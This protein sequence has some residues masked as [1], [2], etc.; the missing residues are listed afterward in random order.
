MMPAPSKA[1]MATVKLFSHNAVRDLD[2]LF[3]AL[4]TRS[5]MTV[6]RRLKEVGYLSS[7]TDAGRY[8][9]LVGIPEFDEDG[10]WF[11]HGVGFSRAGTLK[12]TVAALV[13]AADTGLMH[14]ELEARL[15]VRVHNTL[16]GLVRAQRI[17]RERVGGQFVYVSAETGRLAAQLACRR[18]MVD[19]APRAAPPLP[20][21]LVIAVLVEVLHSCMGLAPSAVIAR[22]LATRGEAVTAEQVQR[23]YTE[24]G[25]VAGK[26]T[27]EPP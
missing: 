25:L 24:H 5:R 13:E 2:A 19:G 14:R 9:T 10:L 23:I 17:G 21:E 3:D 7:Y 26:K 27:V 20:T 6:F 18:V 16:L 4:G 1:A 8:Y 12:Q 11:R 15:R 22:R